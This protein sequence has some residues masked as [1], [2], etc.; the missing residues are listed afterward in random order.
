MVEMNLVGAF[1][2]E[3]IEAGY[4]YLEKVGLSS[5]LGEILKQGFGCCS[6]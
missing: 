4:L 2:G 5:F 3:K 1:F 6:S